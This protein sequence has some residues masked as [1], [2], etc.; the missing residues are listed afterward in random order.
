MAATIPMRGSFESERSQAMRLLR[1]SRF[2]VAE[3]LQRIQAAARDQGLAVLALMA[4]ARPVLVLASSVGGTPIVMTEADSQP[5]LPLSVM[6]R[7][8]SDGGS[9]V[10]VAAAH[11]GGWQDLPAAVVEDLQALP[12]LVDRALM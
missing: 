11:S 1:H 9:D 4:G 8:V 5:A 6:L 7:E 12:A 3:T 2:G 10:L